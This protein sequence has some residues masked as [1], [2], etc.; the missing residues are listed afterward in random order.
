MSNSEM[1]GLCR[2]GS[3]SLSPMS[4]SGVSSY[5]PEPWR[6]YPFILASYNLLDEWEEWYERIF[7]MNMWALKTSFILQGL[8]GHAVRM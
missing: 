7:K 8:S 4:D 6:E 2:L 1:S 3:G 5:G